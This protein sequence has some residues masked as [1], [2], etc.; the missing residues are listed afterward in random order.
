MSIYIENSTVHY[1]VV[2]SSQTWDLVTDL[3]SN[4]WQDVVLTWKR[5]EGFYF[6]HCTDYD[7]VDH[8]NYNNI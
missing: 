4:E 6:S 5:E 8:D 2:T 7:D 3:V 1:K